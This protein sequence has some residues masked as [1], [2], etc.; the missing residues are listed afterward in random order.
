MIATFTEP[1]LTTIRQ[2]FNSHEEELV[3]RLTE[4]KSSLKRSKAEDTSA[5]LSPIKGPTIKLD[6]P[7]FNGK[8]TDWR[9]FHRLFSS[10]LEN[11]GALFSSHEKVCLLLQAMQTTEAQRIIQSHSHSDDG[12]EQAIEALT[13]KYGS[14]KKVFPILVRRTL[15]K[16]AIDFTEEAFAT[17]R[18]RFLI[19]YLAMV[20]CGCNSLSYYLAALACE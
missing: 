17:L 14:P 6:L 5:S 19:P 8:P 12:F 18:K 11:R 15:E 20:D 1:E 7:K 13:T 10:A 2:T 16:G 4:S 3:R 9:H